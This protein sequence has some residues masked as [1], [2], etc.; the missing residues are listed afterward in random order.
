ME[1]SFSSHKTYRYESLNSD[2]QPKIVLY[3]LHGYGQLAK[4]FIRK[5]NAVP[6]DYLIIAPEGMHRFYLE[7]TN[8]KVGA[9]WMTKEAREIDISDNIHWLNALDHE[10]SSKYNIKQRILLGFSQGGATAIR[11]KLNAHHPFNKTIIWASDFPPDMEPKINEFKGDSSNYFVLGE[12]DEYFSGERQSQII[13]FFESADFKIKTFTGRH[14]I[15][16]SI[17]LEVLNDKNN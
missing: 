11:W 7:G 13:S 17:L 14:H 8:G 15:D 4:Y 12:E 5:F 1:H 10:I 2:K 3:A 16:E 6:E 9:S